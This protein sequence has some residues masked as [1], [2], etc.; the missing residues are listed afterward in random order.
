MGMIVEFRARR[1]GKADKPAAQCSARG[2]AQILFFSGVRYS[3]PDDEN[4][5]LGS[6]ARRKRK[7]HTS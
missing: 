1:G 7:R 6:P 4:R 2:P 3:R 5:P